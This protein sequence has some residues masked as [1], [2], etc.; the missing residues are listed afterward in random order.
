MKQKKFDA[1]CEQGQRTLGKII[2]Y[3]GDNTANIFINGEIEAPEEYIEVN[4]LL[5]SVGSGY[6]INFFINSNGGFCTSG[7]EIAYMIKE[8]NANITSIIT[9][10]CSSAAS[11]IFI[12]SDS[13]IIYDCAYMLIHSLSKDYEYGDVANANKK[14]INDIEYNSIILNNIYGGF[15][16]KKE[17]KEVSEGREMYLYAPE[18]RKRIEKM[19][20]ENR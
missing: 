7:V 14:I 2:Y 10:E 19:K 11:F 3:K 13:H 8:S 20:E 9:N 16:T 17:I 6:N 4:N 1:E 5:S 15:L 18:I 12:K